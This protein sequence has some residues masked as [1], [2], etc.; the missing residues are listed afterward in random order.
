MDKYTAIHIKGTAWKP[1]HAK[2]CL[3]S[4]D[5]VTSVASPHTCSIITTHLSINNAL[6]ILWPEYSVAT[7]FYKRTGGAKYIVDLLCTQS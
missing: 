7:A 6:L 1:Q 4:F 5:L 2:L 3:G